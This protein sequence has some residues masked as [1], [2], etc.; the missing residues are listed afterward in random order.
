M[1]VLSKAVEP[2]GRGMYIV[3][4]HACVYT[5]ESGAASRTR[6]IAHRRGVGCYHFVAVAMVILV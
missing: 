6:G 2:M 4:V 5:Q 3:L 1:E